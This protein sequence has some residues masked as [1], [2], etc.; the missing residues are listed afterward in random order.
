MFEILACGAYQVVDRQGDV[1][2]L[3]TEGQHLAAFSSGEELR[4]R[5]E[6]AL[7][8][9]HLRESVA[10]RGRDEVLARHTYE[11]RARRLLDPQ[12]TA[13]DAGLAAGDA[14]A[15]PAQERGSGPEPRFGAGGG[16]R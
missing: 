14:V 16:T 8:D 11:H 10:R 5:V 1:L 6:Q 15:R 12:A 2:R 13:K 3:F 7:R 4:A 9:D